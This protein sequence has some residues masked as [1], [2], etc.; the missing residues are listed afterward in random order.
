M[1][2]PDS[3]DPL[4]RTLSDWEL[5]PRR[6]PEFRAAV[7]GRVETLRGAAS[8]SG[9]VRSHAALV[10]GALAVAVIAGALGGRE[11]ARARV[12]SDSARLANSYVEAMDARTMR[13]P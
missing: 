8:W 6:T 1:N 10:A 5:M 9:Y 3:S 2:T 7:F 13:M 12:A 11:R 4:S